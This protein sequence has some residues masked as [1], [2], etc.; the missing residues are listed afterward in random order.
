MLPLLS[1]ERG[2]G[3][4]TSEHSLYIARLFCGAS[5]PQNLLSYSKDTLLCSC[6]HPAYYNWCLQCGIGLLPQKLWDL[7]AWSQNRRWKTSGKMRKYGCF[8][9]SSYANIWKSAWLDY[10][11]AKDLI[12]RP[13][14]KAFNILIFGAALLL[15]C[16]SIESSIIQCNSSLIGLSTDWKVNLL[17]NRFLCSSI[18]KVLMYGCPLPKWIRTCIMGENTAISIHFAVTHWQIYQCWSSLDTNFSIRLYECQVRNMYFYQCLFILKSIYYFYHK[19]YYKS[20]A[21]EIFLHQ[22]GY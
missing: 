1:A 12:G 4:A 5:V 22:Y 15:L 9:R 16:L 21:T 18:P 11:F 2:M 7:S 3:S 20:L 10:I 6:E 14:N 19:D 13:V 17:N 8:M